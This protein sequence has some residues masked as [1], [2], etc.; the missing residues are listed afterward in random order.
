MKHLLFEGVESLRLPCSWVLLIPAL[1]MTVFGR[2]RTPLV[3]V[4]FAAAAMLVA[5]LRFAGWWFEVPRG[6]VQIA[7][8]FVIMSGAALAWKSDEGLVDAGV[9][10]IAGMSAVWAWTPC[11]G[12][13]LADVLNN[14]RRDPFDQIGG[15]IAFIFGL[16]LPFVLI[17]AAG[18]LLP[19][20]QEKLEHRSIVTTGAI[21]LGGVGLLFSTTLY[22]DLASALF[23]ISEF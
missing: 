15:T 6:A 13:H 16:L 22:D 12:P 4:V 7:L 5:W 21:L 10:G 19:R 11:V 14:A 18:V 2:R 8:G 3:I 20:L 1:A 9:A 23:R 17:A